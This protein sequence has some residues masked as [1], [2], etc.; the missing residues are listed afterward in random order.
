ME[1]PVIDATRVLEVW[2]VKTVH[3]SAEALL[4]SVKTDAAAANVDVLVLRADRIFGA[5]HLKSALYH[6][7]KAI[8]EKRN[9]SDSLAMET[10]L[11]ASGER[12]LSTAIKKMAIDQDTTEVVV[13]K[14]TEGEFRPGT[15][16]NTLPATPSVTDK[17]ALVSFGVS[18]VEMATLNPD[19]VRDLVLE[20]VASVDILKK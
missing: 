11:Y 13:A 18:D 4:E 9:A 3:G 1:D 14:L 15:S 12:Q 5:D 16:W 17:K 2:S 20:K 6:A 10:L 19:K 7:I 8:G